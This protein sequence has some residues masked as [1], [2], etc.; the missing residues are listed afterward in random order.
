MPDVRYIYILTFIQ[1]IQKLSAVSWVGHSS[2]AELLLIPLTFT[3]FNYFIDWIIRHVSLFCKG[4]NVVKF[5]HLKGVLLS[6]TDVNPRDDAMLL[7][8]PAMNNDYNFLWW[9]LARCCY[10]SCSATWLKSS[11][12]YSLLWYKRLSAVSCSSSFKLTHSRL[13]VVA[14]SS[15]SGRRLSPDCLLFWELS[16]WELKLWRCVGWKRES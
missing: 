6:V 14:R 3:Q 10:S 2:S 7:N 8:F 12:T 16:S 4:G 15:I 13:H 9:N 11:L 5:Q 1:N